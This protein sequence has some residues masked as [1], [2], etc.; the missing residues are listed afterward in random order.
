MQKTI[1]VV[2]DNRMMREF[3]SNLLQGQG[4]KVFLAENGFEALNSL[5]STRP[6]IIFIDAVIKPMTK[7]QAVAWHYTFQSLYNAVEHWF[8][9]VAFSA[10][11]QTDFDIEAKNRGF[12]L[13]V[14]P[15]KQKRI[16]KDIR[17]ETLSGPAERLKLFFCV[18]NNNVPKLIE[19]FLF[20]GNSGVP[21]DGPDAAA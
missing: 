12:T 21:K 2:D 20:Y 11:M 8:E 15:Y 18:E 1:L 6:D 10:W 7:K 5:T 4:H 13:N 19:Q 16:H 3:M 14:R 9:S 17:V